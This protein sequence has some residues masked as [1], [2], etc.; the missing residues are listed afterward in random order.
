VIDV[1]E[2]QHQAAR[3]L[4]PVVWDAATKGSPLTYKSAASVLGRNPDKN[5]R[6]V[7][8]VCDLLDAAAAYA[9]VPLLAFP[10]VRE[11]GGGFNRKAFAREPY[12]DK[13]L[14][15]SLQHKFTVE[16]RNAIASALEKLSGRGNL[17]AWK[18][19]LSEVK[20][21]DFGLE[22]GPLH[23]P[24]N[25]DA[26]DDIGSES[27]LSFKVI[28][29]AY[30]RDTRIRSAVMARAEGLCE[31]C[32]ESGFIKHDGDPYLECHHIIALANDGADRMT[33]VIALCADHHREAHFGAR[34]VSLETEMIERVKAAEEKRRRGK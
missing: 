8:Q 12:R 7:A 13:L 33:N 5:Q 11:Q 28:S 23:A 24:A 17:R 2:I 10:T 29:T 30:A 20:F 1:S 19:V 31:Y 4:L 16:D 27:P 15:M 9:G 25:I 3:N 34:R 14:A 22:L 32:G 18:L 6:M 26:L 21:P